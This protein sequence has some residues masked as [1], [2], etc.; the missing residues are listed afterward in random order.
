MHRKTKQRINNV[1]TIEENMMGFYGPPTNC[2]ELGRIG[3]TLNGYYLVRSDKNQPK[4]KSEGEM[5]V[6]FCRFQF[7]PGG[8]DGK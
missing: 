5:E 1:V 4:A 7:P 3:Y 2:K 8:E 6:V